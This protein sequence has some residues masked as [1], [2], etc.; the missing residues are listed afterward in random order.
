MLFKFRIWSFIYME[1]LKRNLTPRREEVYGNWEV[2][3]P[4]DEVIFYC[5]EKV[6]N[7]YLSR[8]LATLTQNKEI[9]LSFTPRGRGDFGKPLLHPKENRCVVCGSFEDLTQHHVVPK[10]YRKHLPERYKTHASYD[11]VCIC[12]DCHD[13]YEREYADEF[14]IEL[15][16]KYSD[17]DR[18]NR[19]ENSVFRLASALQSYNDVMPERRKDQI[20]SQIKE[21]LNTDELIDI[22]ELVK[23]KPT[24]FTIDF[25]KLV[26]DDL[27]NYND[28][29]MKWR[30]H[31]VT[32]MRPKYMPKGWKINYKY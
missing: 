21:I 19:D 16:S 26:V 15:N 4:D 20:I 2:K 14:K 17:D 24:C 5:S 30:K 9:K 28:F 10:C 22:D 27:E 29:I 11:V 13:K 32:S 25:G 18:K 12:V 1:N 23:E 6:A 7:W 31:F 8:S 3:N